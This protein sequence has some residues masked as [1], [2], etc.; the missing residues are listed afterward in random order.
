[1]RIFVVVLFSAF[2]ANI[3][4]AVPINISEIIYP[5]TKTTHFGQADDVGFAARAPPLAVSNV[6]GSGGTGVALCTIGG[7]AIIIHGLD[8]ASTGMDIFISGEG[9]QTIG[10]VQLQALG[11]ALGLP[12]SVIDATILAYDIAG[13]IGV[14]GTV[15]FGRLSR[16]DVVQDVVDTAT[17]RG[18]GSNSYVELL[19]RSIGSQADNFSGG[20]YQTV[21]TTEETVIYRSFGGDARLQG[22]YA[23]PTQGAS[24]SDLAIEPDWGNSM[25]FEATVI[26]PR[27]TTLNVGT[28]GPQATL[29]GGGSQILMPRGWN[30]IPVNNNTVRITDTST[31]RTYSYNEFATE[32]PDLTR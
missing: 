11:D 28:A 32:F 17:N 4:F 29:P 14:T 23:T 2:G 7:Y 18:L 9:Q 21:R 10:A 8:N 27:G 20:A 31:G 24:R 26:V 6:A 1:M 25:R 22:G 3:A 13:P 5:Q 19:P 12:Q 30:G 15:A 16:T